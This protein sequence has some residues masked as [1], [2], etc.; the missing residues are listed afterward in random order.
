[1]K[2]I[3][4][5]SFEEKQLNQLKNESNEIGESVAT[6]VRQAVNNYFLNKRPTK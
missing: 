1:M 5:I 3:I 6:I 4:Q 2:K